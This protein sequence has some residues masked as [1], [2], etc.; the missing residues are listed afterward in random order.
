MKYLVLALSCLLLAIPCYAEII[1]VDDDWPYDFNNIQA[2]I[3]YSAD[4]DAIYVFPG[5]YTGPGNWDIDFNSRAIAV[6]SVDRLNPYIVAAT[7]IDCNDVNYH[8]GFV[9]EGG[10]DANS[11]LAGFT[12]TNARGAIRCYNSSPTIADCVFTKST[13]T[14]VYC[15]NS[16]PSIINCTITNNS[17]SQGGGISCV[18]SSPSIIDCTI[19]N[20]SG[21]SGGGIYCD[22]DGS[23][24][25]SD[26]NISHNASI[27]EGGGIYCK[28]GASVTIDNCTIIANSTNSAVQPGGGIYCESGDLTIS[29]SVI[30]ANTAEFGG[31]IYHIGSGNATINAS[32][33]A[34]NAATFD[35]G[36]IY[37]RAATLSL[38]NSIL[39]ANTDS[40]PTD[41]SAQIDTDT[42]YPPQV[43]YSCIQD[44]NP[45]DG[46]I[47]FGAGDPNYNIDDDPCFVGYPNNFS[48]LHLQFNSP[49]IEAGL[50]NYIAGPN[51]LDID[52]QPRIIGR[53]IDMGADEYHKIM[54]VT[55][56]AGGEI[57]T[58]GSSHQ[59]NWESYG[60]TGNVTIFG[61]D[62]S[63][64]EFL[65]IAESVPD[66]G[67]YIWNLP[68]SVDSN[69][70]R[71]DV[72]PHDIDI[73]V[74]I[75]PS[76]LFTIKPYSPGSP[77]AAKWK[78]LAGDFDRAGL[79]DY[80]GPEIGCIKWQFQTS[81]PVSAS[82]TVADNNTVHIACEDGNLYT[83]DA[84][85]GS[86][87]WTY[88]VDSPLLSSPTIGRDG[89]VYV[90]AQNGT[91][92]AIDVN[93]DLQW[94]HATS[95]FIYSSPVVSHD[96]N[97]IYV[98]SQDG[99]LYAL[100][101]DGSEL[102]TFQTEGPGIATGAIFASPAIGPDGTVYIAGVYDPNLYALDPDTGSVIW[103]C[104]FLDP[105]DPNTEK[106][107]PFASPVVAQDGTIYQ[108]LLYNPKRIVG[109][110]PYEYEYGF[111]YDSKLYAIDPN[112]GQILWATNMSQTATFVELLDPDPPEPNY[113]FEQYYVNTREAPIPPYPYTF[114]KAAGKGFIRYYRVSNSSYSEPALGPDGTIYVTLEDQYVRTVDPNGTIKGVTSLGWFGGFSLTVGADGLIYAAGDDGYL[115][116]VDPDG[117]EIAR[118]ETDSHLSFPVITED[119]T[120]IVNDANNTVTAI[121]DDDCPGQPPALHRPEDLNVDWRMNFIDFGILAA[122][123]LDCSDMSFEPYHTW[124]VCDYDG[125]DIFLTGDINRDLYVNLFDLAQ[126]AMRWLAQD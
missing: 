88:E 82:A 65:P 96:G 40:G 66:T 116:V 8:P 30:T 29:N 58:A 12:V 16:S 106:P 68:A 57:W 72:F 45:D 48:D 52:G 113:W 104:N 85:D 10:E 107:W 53:Q 83:L 87:L 108:A 121:I 126:L 11:V 91:L 28:G 1:I 63:V 120:I 44:G 34:A 78:S 41:L 95:G 100:A 5:T 117:L 59:I 60:V 123:W 13:L 125:N 112:D 92:Y 20:N 105:C 55:K 18:N 73:T 49:C 98:G 51:V 114:S 14:A 50:P 39:W 21:S 23:P 111:W 27:N 43:F 67:A 110:L 3:D 115:Y 56:P 61:L 79:S 31:A 2:A 25:I 46:Y 122:D 86:L 15:L 19:T 71:V 93:G 37:S 109:E 54:I 77:V 36:G 7:V 33:I 4:G 24:I 62:N 9:F 103:D 70:V 38:T 90:G 69:Q 6:Q 99:S 47:P 97:N 17:G 101:H 124:T 74:T 89:T 94:T 42:E 75:V 64:P 80:L 76:G 81:A 118:Y 22:D 35:A 102:W 84:N 26:S 119:G 32:T